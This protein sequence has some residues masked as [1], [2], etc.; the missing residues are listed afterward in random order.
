M[1]ADTGAIFDI[2]RYSLHDGPGIRTTVFVKGCPLRCRW[3]HNPEGWTAR[4][5]IRVQSNLCIHCGECAAVCPNGCHTGDAWNSAGCTLCGRCVD[6]CPVGAIERVG[7]RMT[8]DEVMAVVRRDRPFYDQSG[9]GMTISGGEPLLQISFTQAL[10]QAA[11]EDG[12]NTA[13]ETSAFA[14]WESLARLLPLVDTW[15]VDLKHTDPTRHR[16]LT[17]VDNARILA[18]IRRLSEVV[19]LLIRIPW[20]PTCNAEESFLDGLLAFLPQGST[21]EFMPY[22]RLGI[23]KWASLGEES[24]ISGDLPDA[25]KD[26]LHPWVERLT[27]AGVRVI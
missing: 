16:E 24:P 19:P 13:I 2:Q 3:C 27:E 22:H 23:G 4:E 12:L 18:N 10:L 7:R 1:T 5:Q 14:S 26:D 15:M 25:A 17:G 6:A 9:G 21:V 8:V 20:V 11:K